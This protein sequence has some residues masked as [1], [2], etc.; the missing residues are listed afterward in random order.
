MALIVEGIEAIKNMKGKRLEPGPWREVTFEQIRAF[1]DA[2][3]DH[4]WI[5]EDRERCARES[6]FGKPIAHGYYTLS[7]VPV[8]MAQTIEVRGVKMGVNYGINKL[9]FPA[10]VP[11]GSRVRFSGT[12]A[13]VEEIPGGVQLVVAGA[14]EVEGSEKPALAAELVYRYYG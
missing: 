10:P 7:I 12:V 4:Q 1:A 6:P 8:L 2:T 3:G 9:R 5:H 11:E 14:V 13:G